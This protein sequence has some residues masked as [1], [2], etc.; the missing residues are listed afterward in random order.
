V[1]TQ[2]SFQFPATIDLSVVIVNYNGRDHLPA[3]LASLEACRTE[4]DFEIIVVD[5]D[6]Q[7]GSVPLVREHF[8]Q[9]RVLELDTNLGFG[10]ANNAGF[11]IARGRFLLALNPDTVM[12]PGVLSSAVRRLEA[13]SRIGV[14]GVGQRDMH[15]HE[16]SSAMRLH[17]PGFFF[18]AAL[19]PTRLRRAIGGSMNLRYEERDPGS[20]FECEAVVGCF[21][22]MPRSLVERIG[23]F[24]DRIFM[25][26][27]ELEFCWRVRQAGRSVV[28]AGDLHITHAIGGTTGGMPV[29]RSVQMQ[30]GQLLALRFTQGDGSARLAALGMIV[31]HVA[32]LP[33][34]LLSV[35]RGYRKRLKSRLL[36]LRDAASAIVRLPLSS[37]HRID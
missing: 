11:A 23:G 21:M 29:W 16:H 7:D 5:N 27:E 13:D 24:D 2:V 36:R 19:A 35:G 34:E 22:A 37:T 15:G 3:C 1:A 10:A 6:S 12:P 31:S 32:R 33:L 14:V 30:K 9:V 25:Y 28:Y 17:R 18:L 20:T 26:G 4:L 8:P